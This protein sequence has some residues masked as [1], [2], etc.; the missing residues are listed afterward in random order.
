MSWFLALTM[1]ANLYKAFPEGQWYSGSPR[2]AFVAAVYFD[3]RELS[4]GCG[5][6]AAISSAA[7]VN[8]FPD[9]EFSSPRAGPTA[10]PTLF[11]QEAGLA[12]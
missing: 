8:S 2:E 6:E 10:G 7:A 9:L 11:I 4:V 12:P 5:Q 3:L 1:R